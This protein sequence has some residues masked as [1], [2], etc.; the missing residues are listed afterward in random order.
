MLTPVRTI[1]DQLRS[2]KQFP[3][4]QIAVATIAGPP[5]PYTVKWH[6]PYF[7]DT[8]PWPEVAQSCTASDASWADP[9]VRLTQ[10]AAAFGNNGVSVSVCNT[11]Y[12]VSFQR[13]A[14]ILPQ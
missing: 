14:E 3:D 10:W 7:A 5:T 4:Q 8:G 2:L 12:A 1:V 6:A 11:D 9:A 13:L